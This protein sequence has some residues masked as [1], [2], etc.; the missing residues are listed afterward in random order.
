MDQCRRILSEKPIPK[1]KVLCDLLADSFL[2]SEFASGSTLPCSQSPMLQKITKDDFFPSSVNFYSVREQNEILKGYYYLYPFIFL[3]FFSFL[4]NRVQSPQ[5][6]QNSSW[7]LPYWI[8]RDYC[9]H[10]ELGAVWGKV[11]GG[12]L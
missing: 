12:V 6:S 3:K 10:L 4:R 1:K 9:I 8:L 2:S 11:Q 5:W 7:S